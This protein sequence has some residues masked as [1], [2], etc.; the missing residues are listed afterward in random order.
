ME[1]QSGKMT[2]STPEAANGRGRPATGRGIKIGLY[3]SV[4]RLAKLGPNP[5]KV[6]YFLIDKMKKAK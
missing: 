6:I 4:K 1:R 5:A 2:P 3:L